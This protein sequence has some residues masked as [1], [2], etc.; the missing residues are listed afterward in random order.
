MKLSGALLALLA[1]S[2]GNMM[3]AALSFNYDFATLGA[4]SKGT[5]FNGNVDGNAVAGLGA[6]A[7]FSLVSVNGAKTTWTFDVKVTE[8]GSLD[9]RVSGL[10][11]KDIAPNAAGGSIASGE[12]GGTGWTFISGG[13]FPNGFGSLEAC[14]SNPPNCQGGGGGGVANGTNRTARF[15]LNFGSATDTVVFNSLGVRYQS[16]SGTSGNTTFNG[17]SGT[18][19]DIGD[20][21]VPGNEPGVPEPSTVALIG[22]GLTGLAVASRRRK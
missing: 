10:G 21:F 5:S 2:V 16:I 4:Q 8:T 1:L 11:F 14:L 20:P 3:G 13:S 6:T 18:G 7:M 22:L 9:A 19:R 12:D 15:S 17:D